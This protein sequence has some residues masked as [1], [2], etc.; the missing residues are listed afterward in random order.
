M[1]P[2]KRKLCAWITIC[3]L[4]V[5][6]ACGGGKTQTVKLSYSVVGVTMEYQLEAAGDRVKTITQNSVVDTSVY[7][8][9]EIQMILDSMNEFAGTYEAIEGVTYTTEATDETLTETLV[10]DA[11][12]R[13]TLQ[14]LIEAGLLPMEGE[15]NFLFISLE[16]TVAGLEEQGWVVVE[17]EE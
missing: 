1:K 17:G 4:L 10:I 16:K 13:D 6:S 14:T 15:E 2:T 7:S 11:T 5:L 3:L 9:E 12:N 8:E